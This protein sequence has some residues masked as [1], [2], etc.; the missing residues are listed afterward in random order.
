[1]EPKPVWQ[2]L[3]HMRLWQQRLSP[4]IDA[5]LAQRHELVV[6][7]GWLYTALRGYFL[8]SRCGALFIVFCPPHPSNIPIPPPAHK[9]NHVNILWK[10]QQ[11]PLQYCHNINIKV[12]GLK[13]LWC[14][15]WSLSPSIQGAFRGISK[16][17]D[18]Y[19]ISWY[20]LKISW[21]HFSLP[22]YWDLAWSIV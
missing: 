1:M 12:F 3:K 6:G 8:V 4:L 20:H 22:Q 15:N 9:S 16:Y 2:T 17:W 21:Y 7:A 14:Y 5:Y 18:T 10:H 11:S 13:M 19:H